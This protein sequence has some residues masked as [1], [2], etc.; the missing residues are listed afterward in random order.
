ME[1]ENFL[2]E[3]EE[4]DENEMLESLYEGEI[5]YPDLLKKYQAGERDFSGMNLTGINLH[6]RYLLGI[7][8][9]SANLQCAS[10]GHT[11]LTQASLK[12]ANLENAHL[13]S[14]YLVNANL[15]NANLTGAN[16]NYANLTGANLAGANLT[17]VTLNQAK[18]SEANLSGA[19]WQNVSTESAIFCQTIMPDGTL[20]NDPNRVVSPQE[21]LRRYAAGE[22]K[23]EGII[24]HRADLRGIHLRN[25]AMPD[26]HLDYAN[27]S[28]ANLEHS[29]L[30]R[31]S[32]RGADLSGA[33]LYLV[34]LDGA[35]FSYADLRN[36]SFQP[37]GEMMGTDFT[38]ANLLGAE[39]MFTKHC[40]FHRTIVPN[41]TLVV[42]PSS[43]PW[44]D[45]Y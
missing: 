4:S 31:V 32:F 13:S 45:D 36:S 21:F 35:D 14:A 24:L 5:D 27:L 43:Y 29:Y 1:P 10:F 20:Y 11:D 9:N 41:G 30:R 16:L 34:N 17:D 22:R 40:F 44:N 8:F 23:F 39:I 42:G 3:F 6:D 7:N 33:N 28:G 37:E 26:A 19:T 12:N 25:V 2:D 18:L 38:E 15:E